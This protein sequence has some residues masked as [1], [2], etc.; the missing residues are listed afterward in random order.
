MHHDDAGGGRKLMLVDV[1]V[2]IVYSMYLYIKPEKNF[3]TVCTVF[4]GY[5][6][7]A[8]YDFHIKCMS[9]I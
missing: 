4:I 5:I 8:L 9:M 3:S 6:Y 1:V 7:Y 2:V